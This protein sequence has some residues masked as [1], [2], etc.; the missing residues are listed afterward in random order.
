MTGPSRPIQV[1]VASGPADPKRV[2]LGL[3]LA[4]A[5]AS[6]GT[7]VRLFLTMDGV[8]CLDPGVCRRE[9]LAGYP[10]IADLLEAIHGSGGVIEY[11]PNC[12]PQGCDGRLAKAAGGADSPCGCSGV[13]AGLASYGV[14]LAD[15]PTFI[16]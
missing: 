13:P 1:I 9:L 6:A 12:L 14:R 15:Y 4:A 5:A 16:F 11:C 3:S 2:L 8:Q 7:I 10:P